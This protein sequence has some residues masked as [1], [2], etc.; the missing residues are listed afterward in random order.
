MRP[1]DDES[2]I[3]QMMVQKFDLTVATIN[4]DQAAAALGL[5]G[6]QLVT[7]ASI[8]EREAKLDEDRG[9]IASV[10]YN[11]LH[12]GMLLQIAPHAQSLRANLVEREGQRH[13]RDTENERGAEA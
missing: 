12:K 3:L 9:P 7:V 5:T 6:Y 13:G 10:I 1:S 4:L 11:R 2:K 8:V